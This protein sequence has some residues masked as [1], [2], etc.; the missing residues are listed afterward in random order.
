MNAQTVSIIGV[1]VDLG[2]GRRGVDMGPSAVRYASLRA[3]IEGVGR[4]VSRCGNIAVPTLDE[5]PRRPLGSVCAICC[6][7]PQ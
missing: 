5:L 4:I 2:A 1:P 3:R 6:R 7:W